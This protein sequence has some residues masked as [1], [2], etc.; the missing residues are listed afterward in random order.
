MCTYTTDKTNIY[1][2]W[3]FV[4][5][6]LAAYAANNEPSLKRVDLSH[7]RDVEAVVNRKRNL[8]WYYYIDTL[9]YIIKKNSQT[10]KRNSQHVSDNYLVEKEISRR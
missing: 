6:N 9:Y 7:G 1:F 2:L 5:S 10:E 4:N 3:Y 8:K